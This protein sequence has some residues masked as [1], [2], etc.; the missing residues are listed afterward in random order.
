MQNGRRT[1]E[2][3]LKAGIVISLILHG[4][5]FGLGYF[6]S[7]HATHATGIAAIPP[8][9]FLITMNDVQE[10]GTAIP[11]KPSPELTKRASIPEAPN[12]AAPDSVRPV[13]S[14][15]QSHAEV[16]GPAHEMTPSERTAII[17]NYLSKLRPIIEAKLTG[18]LK[19]RF[20]LEFTIYNDGHISVE[21][22]ES[23]T[24]SLATVRFDAF[25]PELISALGDQNSIRVKLP[26][27][28]N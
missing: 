6:S 11:K 12:A 17:K 28:V 14:V 5:F 7:R 26:V 18:Q 25:S 3:S 27:E 13:P 16:I 21:N 24:E 10:M 22:K 23:I 19:E 2:V 9:T 15:S 4:A 20:M 1:N 8:T